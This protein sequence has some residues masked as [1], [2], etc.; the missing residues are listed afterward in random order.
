[1][2][3]GFYLHEENGKKAVTI[4]ESHPLYK[5]FL[6]WMEPNPYEKLWFTKD[7]DGKPGKG[8]LDRSE[9]WFFD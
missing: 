9:A 2:N 8:R 4:Y 5:I 6:W 3:E 1:M 7:K